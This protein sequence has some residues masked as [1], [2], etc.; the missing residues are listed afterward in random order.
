MKIVT[1][2]QMRQIEARSEQ[3]GVS[4][5][6]LME[7]AGL[8]VAKRVRHHLGPLV[9]VPIVVL[10]GPG[11]N[12]GDGLVTAR[13]LHNWGA[14]VLAYLCAERREPDPRLAIVHDLGLPILRASQDAGL[15]RLK[16]ALASA[17][18]VIDAVLG[19][20]RSRP[21]DGILKDILLELAQAR[22]RRGDLRVLALD[23]PTGLNADTGAVDPVCPAADVT[24][25]LGY[26]KVGLFAFPGA[27]RVGKLEVVDIG[28][29]PGLDGDVRLEL[30][31][32]AWARSA[33]PR[34]PSSAH[35]GTF[36]RTLVVAGSRNYVGAAYLAATAATR[37]GAGLVTL[38]I[39]QSLQAAVAA[40][41]VEPTY[42]PLPE[43]SPGVVSPEAINSIV[44]A[45]PGYNALLVGCG[46]GQEANT[47]ELVVRLLCS[48]APLPPA[49]V[50]ADGLNTLS[51]DTGWWERFSTRAIVTPHPGEMARLTGEPASA[52]QA[53][54]VGR[55]VESAV[56]WN[57]VT[58][59]KGAYTVVAFPDGG[60]MLSPFANPGLAS[61][62]TG[63]VLAGAIVG[64]LSQGLTLEN[65]A[66]LGV[67]L[68]GAAGE[69]V[70]GELGDTGMIAS[71][72]L[73]TLSRVLKELRNI[74]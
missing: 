58:V 41:A 55:A 21:V 40:R 29:P 47:R 22:A 17:H 3:A 74:G 16:E 28:I 1:S 49:V 68:H 44:E 18:M 54:R 20:G 30:M 15:A 63:D 67:Y 35:K 45:L 53:D 6:T 52:V 33:L 48:G 25:T 7:V 57:K 31:T 50:D 23:L 69:R 9:G 11:N 38:A 2:E 70:R 26:P 14:R 19:T 43:S 13:H 27:D 4:T 8:A 46:L 56:K 42:L 34:R 65:A 51:G 72:L 66:A 12:G 60:A 10:V 64:L 61:A 39:P 32:P 59:L 24:V 73:P 62:G 37:V 5:D 71:D 36:G